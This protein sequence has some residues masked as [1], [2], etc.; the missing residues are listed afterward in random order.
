MATAAAGSKRGGGRGRK[1]LVAVLDN[2]ANI[3][4]GKA[5]KAGDLSASSAPKAKRAPA[6]SGKAA[7]AAAAAASVVDDVA[8]LQGMLERLRL[9]KEKAEEMVRERDE[10]IRKKEEEIETKEKEQE[11]LQAELRK[12]QRAKEF[13][14]T[15]S[16]PLVKS[17]LEK[18]QDAG[19]KGKRKKGKG[20]AVPERKKPCTAYVLWLKDQWAEIKKENPEADFKEVTNTLGAKWK[21]LGAEEKQPYEERYR[22]EKEAY[23]QVV[24]QEKR[25]AEAMKLLEEQQMQWTAKELLEQYLK[26]RQEAEEGDGKKGKRK[27]SK[28][29]KDPAK[30]KQPMSAYF[31]YTQERR[32]ALVA[33]KKNVPEIGKIT[34]EEWKNMT[35]AQKAPYEEVAKKQKEEYHKQ[36]GVYKKKKIE[37]AASLEKEEE[38]QKKIMKQEAL[39]LL[40]KK[41]KADNIIKKTKEKRQKKKQENVDPSRPKKP[42]S[43]FLLFSKEA[44]KQLLEERPGINNST[45]NALI[46]VK[47]KELSGEERQAW[48]DKAAPAMAAYKKE[49]EEYTKAHSSSA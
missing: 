23:L 3:S 43:S 31:V 20:K 46:S 34:G 14:P 2:D 42:A 12:V 22:Q 36:M 49:M 40:K 1:A 47:W 41:E 15:V 16:F 17:L 33:E 44:R 13:K 7:K 39:Q 26:F 30:P 37:E 10:V 32:A 48:N 35:E 27:N 19:D 25:E 4:A 5:A 6:R 9:E 28:K 29:V 38:E 11:R 45:L 21:A 18:E 24:G 8:E